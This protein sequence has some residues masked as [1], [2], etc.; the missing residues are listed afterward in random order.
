MLTV[1]ESRCKCYIMSM[2]E[3][4]A[5]RAMLCVSNKK[6]GD[7]WKCSVWSTANLKIIDP[8]HIPNT[9]AD[10]RTETNYTTVM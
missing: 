5:G 7:R 6:V 8:P 4:T 3:R 10:H 2:D 1:T 9:S